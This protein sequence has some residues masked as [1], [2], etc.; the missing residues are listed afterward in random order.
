MPTTIQH[1]YEEIVNQIVNLKTDKDQLI[2]NNL[3]KLIRTLSGDVNNNNINVEFV[4]EIEVIKQYRQSLMNCENVYFFG[5]VIQKFQDLKVITMAESY[6]NTPRLFY[7]D[8][9]L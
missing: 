4:N 3:L 1:L 8:G 9:Y 6:E 5:S 7:R 2:I